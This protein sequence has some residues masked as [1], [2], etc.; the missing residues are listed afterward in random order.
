MFKEYHKIHRLGK[1]ETD[2]ILV[3]KC[4]ISEK[5]GGLPPF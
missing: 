3:G 2:R 4:F 1:E 5:I